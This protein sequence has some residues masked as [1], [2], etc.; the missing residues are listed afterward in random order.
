MQPLNIEAL[1]ANYQPIDLQASSPQQP[2]RKGPGG[3]SGLLL[4][5]LPMVA[6]GAGAALGTLALPGAGTLAG[7]SL[8]SGLGEF[9][10]QKLTGESDDGFDIGNVAKE[11]AFGALP[12]AFKTVGMLRNA[13]A[14]EGGIKA[15]G[16]LKGVLTTNL[17]KGS[18]AAQQT[19]EGAM[20]ARMPLTRR[21]GAALTRSGS[22]LK[23]GKNVGDVNRLDELSTVAANYPGT[24]KTQLRKIAAD[25]NNL[26]SQVDDILV[27]TPV[28]IDGSAVGKRLQNA[29]TDLTD[30]RFVDLDLTNPAVQKI[31]G[32]YSSKF[33]QAKDAKGVNDIVKTLNKTATRAV[34]KLANPSAAPL[35]A[36]ETAALALKRAGDDVLS[37]IPEIAPLKQQMAQLFDLN[38]QVAVTAERG[39][40][41]PFTQGSAVSIKAPYQALK[42]AQS[43][44]GALVQGVDNVPGFR[45][46][47]VRQVARATLPQA[48]YRAAGAA[49]GVPFVGSGQPQEAPI[50]NLEPQVDTLNPAMDQSYQPSVSNSPFSEENIQ[51]LVIQDIQST[52]GKNVNTLLKLYETFG[53]TEQA[54]PVKQTEA[55]R[56]RDEAAALTEDALAQLEAGSINTGFASGKVEGVKSFFGAA[57][58][59][60]A[61]FN[62]TIS[63]LKAAIAKARAGTSFT[64]NEERLL[65]QYAPKVGDSGQQLRT[66]LRNL[67]RIYS[68][69]Q[70]REANVEY[71]PAPV[72]GAQ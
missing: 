72:Y 50:D 42:G 16:G 49:F 47:F 45:A 55:Q 11:G 20:Q 7:G 12:G 28:R 51:Q 68:Q 44:A 32:R 27:K 64:P 70:E 8:G 61:D 2:Q 4:N 9:L 71:A 53:Q 40:P 29:V 31:I 3:L 35:S 66:K 34:D 37:E 43:R 38:P 23:V 1:R 15:A 59:E 60:T 17:T 30:E 33:A 5:F 62:T 18:R 24:P 52:G 22:G 36:Q 6:G 58:Q 19:T 57:D 69:A 21:T 65:N 41:I 48:G 25:M 39:F 54:K 56:A 63:A 10:R 67:Q 13:R 46:P 26:S 14:A